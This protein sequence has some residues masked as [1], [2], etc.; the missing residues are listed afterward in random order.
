MKTEK[1]TKTERKAIN[2]LENIESC[3][4][5]VNSIYTNRAFINSTYTE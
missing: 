4:R 3:G 1:K 5:N 2:L